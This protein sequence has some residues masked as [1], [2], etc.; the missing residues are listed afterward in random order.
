MTNSLIR[1]ILIFIGVAILFLLFWYF[2]NLVSYIVI[3]AVIALISKPLMRLLNRVKIF[4]KPVPKALNSILVILLFWFLAILFFRVFTP[5]IAEQGQELSKI[6]R[7][8]LKQGLQEPLDKLSV[9]FGSFGFSEDG[10]NSFSEYATKGITGFLTVNHLS[11]FFKTVLSF[12]G[13]IFIG[14]FSISFILFFFLKDEKLFPSMVYFFI[15]EKHHLK[16]KHA[17]LKIEELL[18]RY[19]IGIIVQL[20]LIITL[21]TTGLLIVGLPFNT[22]ILIGLFLGLF[23]IIPYVGPLIGGGFGLIIGIATHIHL[24]IGNDM[25]A[26]LG[27]MVLVFAT[28]QI[29]DNI[30]FQPIIFSSSV[31]AHPLEIFIVIMIAG[32][33]AGI[34]GMILAVPVYTILRVIALEFFSN[35]RLVKKMT[36]NI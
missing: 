16:T 33:L 36:E 19:L 27:A 24:G 7:E 25:F 15:P 13:D 1:N 3:A 10:E 5:I 2:R 29:I 4:G 20:T 12:L 8:E 22:A 26:I 31:K 32:T 21:I 28:V 18:I 6:S 11:E 35:F 14:I 23:N 17:M 30:L 9:F 34:P